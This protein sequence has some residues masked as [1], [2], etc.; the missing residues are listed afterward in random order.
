[1]GGHLPVTFDWDKVVAEQRQEK[2]AAVS[3]RINGG[4]QKLP[5]WVDLVD[6]LAEPTPDRDWVIEGLLERQGRVLIAADA[7]SGKSLL[8]LT[9]AMQAAAAHP[10][11]E[12]FPVSIPR[13]V[14]YVDLEMSR[15]S[16]MRR[17]NSLRITSGVQR[18]G[19]RFFLRPD[20]LD[21]HNR[22][23]REELESK[24]VEFQ[25]ELLVIDPFYKLSNGDSFRESEVK[26]ALFFLDR[27]RDIVGCGVMLL[28]H[29]RKAQAGDF[30]RKGGADVYGSALLKWWPEV[31]VLLDR[32]NN[33][34]LI[35]KDRD[36]F[37]E[38]R[39]AWPMV[40]GGHW[41]VSLGDSV[42]LDSEDVFGYLRD[43]G[44][45]SGNKIAR[46]LHKRRQ[47]ISSSLT[48]LQIRGL[49]AKRGNNWV[50]TEDRV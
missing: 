5:A 4:R 27:L 32:E 16:V 40:W 30:N 22:K 29:M 36:A 45:A 14:M 35:D 28:H 41:P 47:V 25:P 43:F 17:A 19:F 38:T 13:R 2:A 50:A 34:L 31:V 46:E 49:I 42:N 21:L 1:V 23:Q 15:S 11:W 8:A 10:V 48:D 9:A 18:G 7:E 24:V 37:F 6:F 39:R 20:G 44:P 12:V 3:A 33:R 26:P